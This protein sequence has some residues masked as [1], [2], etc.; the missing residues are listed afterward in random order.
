MEIDRWVFAGESGP[1]GH[2]LLV[3]DTNEYFENPVYTPIPDNNITG[4]ITWTLSRDVKYAQDKYV[5]VGTGTKNGKSCPIIYSLN[6]INWVAANIPN[7][8][9]SAVFSGMSIEFNGTFW[10]MT[11][12]A[13]IPSSNPIT[14][15]ILTSSN[16]IDW[17][18][19]SSTTVSG[20]WTFYKV[21]AHNS[22]P[23]QFI[24]CGDSYIKLGNGQTVRVKVAK[25]D[26]LDSLDFTPVTFNYSVVP[27]RLGVESGDVAIASSDNASKIYEAKTSDY[28]FNESNG[29]FNAKIRSLVC[30]NLIHFAAGQHTNGTVVSASYRH[31][32]LSWFGS[33]AGGF[34]G[35]VANAIFPFTR[36]DTRVV[37]GGEEGQIALSFFIVIHPTEGILWSPFVNKTPSS[38]IR[39]GMIHGIARRP[40]KPPNVPIKT[41]LVGEAGLQGNKILVSDNLLSYDPPNWIPV[42]DEN[43]TDSQM[44]TCI[45]QYGRDV[46]YAQNKWVCV[47]KGTVNDNGTLKSAPVIYS[48]N[49]IDWTLGNL[50]TDYSS[51]IFEGYS[52]E[53]NGTMWVMTC[54]A[55]VNGNTVPTILI[56]SDGVNWNT[57]SETSITGYQIFYKVRWI[58]NKWIMI[59]K[60]RM[61][62]DATPDTE[63]NLAISTDANAGVWSKINWGFSETPHRLAGKGNVLMIMSSDEVNKTFLSIN[64]GS[65]WTTAEEGAFNTKIR[66]LICMTDTHAFEYVA[67]GENNNPKRQVATAFDHTQTWVLRDSSGSFDQIGNALANITYGNME[68]ILIGGD[69]G[70]VDHIKCVLPI[71]GTTSIVYPAIPRNPTEYKLGRIHGIGFQQIDD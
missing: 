36:T 57:H 22:S 60:S 63:V 53:Y 71:V 41:V 35:D 48:T 32:S 10:V 21:V 25:T 30:H 6:G 58:N 54:G 38:N 64:G 15:T 39:L 68:H 33:N 43:I 31:H 40:G 18:E 47:G 2:K 44:R 56:S 61:E 55:T 59:G 4:G 34:V 7:Y 28:N 69:N 16:G 27:H 65:G 20:T 37:V 14:P 67:T 42:P 52:V 19:H 51:S 29:P 24:V 13:E 3:V 5:C 17:V 1:S 26:Q 50:T 12:R 66:D 62:I 45:Y 49:G 8:S 23:R 46:K 70:S 11:C 9:P